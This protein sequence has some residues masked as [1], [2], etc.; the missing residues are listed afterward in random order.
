[1]NKSLF[2]DNY[3]MYEKISNKRMMIFFAIFLSL[4][5][6]P[7]PFIE[8]I[9]GQLNLEKIIYLSI[10]LSIMILLIIYS[11]WSNSNLRK[12]FGLCCPSCNSYLCYNNFQNISEQGVCLKCG[13]EVYID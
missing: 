3:L 12:K 8:K 6:V 13:F 4:L 1:M 2:E 7:L 10:W 11:L 9:N 5:I